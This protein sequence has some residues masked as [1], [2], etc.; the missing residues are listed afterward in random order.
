[1]AAD[2]R[3][4]HPYLRALRLATVG[5][6]LAC[7]ALLMCM[8]VATASAHVPSLEP[9]E[10][11][12][13]TAGRPI[14]GPEVSR[15]IYG[16]LAPGETADT[17]AFTVSEPVTRTIGLIVPAYRE[18]ADFRP[19]LVVRAEGQPDTTIVDPGTS[20]RIASFEPFSLTSFWSGAESEVGF[21]PGTRYL[22]SV[23]PGV[24]AQSGRY[25]IVFGG[26]EQFEA[27]DT[28]TTIAVLPRI[29][30]GAYGGAPVH[31]GS[32]AVVPLVLIVGALVA[33]AVSRVR[34]R[35][36]GAS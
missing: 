18:H 31:L 21:M 26:P 23:E 13:P 15:A 3:I 10:V 27:A 7:G 29:W 9:A 8:P 28:A 35:R 4:N 19:T 2:R 5:F 11:A 32:I 16:Y 1:M 6:A 36:G 20:P 25:V 24:G 34:R 30:F 14:G 12:A 33:F 22:L 17:F